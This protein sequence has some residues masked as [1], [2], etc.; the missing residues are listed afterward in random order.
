MPAH[1]GGMPDKDTAGCI[2][3]TASLTFAVITDYF[4]VRRIF[5][6]HSYLTGIINHETINIFR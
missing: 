1:P 6:I 5:I 4:I 3:K 2:T